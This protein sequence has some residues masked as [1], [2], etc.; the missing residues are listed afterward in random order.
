MNDSPHFQRALLL[1]QQG[2]HEL[3][4]KELRQHLATEPE[5]ATA[6]AFVALC[7]AELDRADAGEAA[8]R[9]AIELE[10]D[11]DWGFYSLAVVLAAKQRLPEAAEAARQAVE[12]DP[13]DAGNH[14][15][16][17]R[18]EIERGRWQAA[19][20]AAERGLALDPGHDV[21]R[22][23]RAN[24]LA[25]LGRKDEAR[26]EAAELVAEDPEDAANHALR[27]WTLLSAGDAAG[28]RGHFLEALRLDP[29][30]EDARTG[31]VQALQARHRIYGWLL[32]GL[33]V[34]DRWG[35][36]VGLAL[37]VGLILISRFA[38][39][40]SDSRPELV[41]PVALFK[42]AIMAVCVASVVAGPLFNLVLFLDR[43]GRQALSAGQ[44]HA[45]RWNAVLLL[46]GLGLA[47]LGLWRGGALLLG[48][49]F[50]YVALTRLV[51]ETFDTPSPWV[52]RRLRWLLL[53][54][55]LLP[56]VAWLMP[57]FGLLAFLGWQINPRPLI[58]ASVW[59]LVLPMLAGLFADNLRVFFERR[60]PD[61][62]PARS[63][64]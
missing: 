1:R 22:F 50:A 60:R 42:F 13:E 10:P 25:Q 40:L 36:G 31:L 44:K 51:N 18:V 59:L 62:D 26:Q 63:P 30:S 45:A 21:C 6:H 12:L 61:T 20:E 33:L 16:L 53:A 2:R 29:N 34:A 49:A 38:T 17:A 24:A 57:L 27:G 15:L 39:R 28:A 58:K 56:V 54:C 48:M 9:R 35:L 3:A 4:E 55:V 52:Y 64:P 19:L 14:A 7:C 23:H 8:A 43:E 47:L 11:S 32:R 5:D 37:G 41:V 46:L